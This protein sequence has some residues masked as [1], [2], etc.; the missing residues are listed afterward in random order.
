MMGGKDTGTG[1]GSNACRNSPDFLPGLAA[2][3]LDQTNHPRQTDQIRD[4]T[5]PAKASRL[6]NGVSS[7]I[8]PYRPETGREN[9][10]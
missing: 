8:S 7:F 5:R 10:A 3:S 9:D 2:Q 1:E 6:A 4:E